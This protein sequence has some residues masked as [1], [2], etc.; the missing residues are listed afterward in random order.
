MASENPVSLDSRL[1]NIER[2]LAT[3]P[4]AAETEADRLLADVPGHGLAQLFKG[5]ARRLDGRFAAAIDI[6]E[7]LCEQ[8][9]D[10]PLAHL[11]LGLAHRQSGNNDKARSAIERAVATNANFGDGW[12]ALADL[13]VEIGDRQ[14]ADKA[15]LSYIAVAGHDPRLQ[16]GGAAIT[17][18]RL[19][20]AERLLRH[21][22]NQ[23]PSDVVALCLLADVAERRDNMPEAEELLTRCVELAP[24]YTRARHNLAVVLLRQNRATE[25]LEQ[26]AIALAAEPGNPEFRKLRAAILV[27]L[28]RYDESIEVCEK[29]LDEDPQQPTVLTSL[30]H[31]LKTVGRR[32]EAVDAYRRAIALAPNYGEPYWS[33]A[34]LKTNTVSDVEMK[35]IQQ[36]LEDENVGL[37]DRLHFHFALGRACE[38]RQDYER[39][40]T[41]YDQGNRIRLELYPYDPQ[42]L[43]DFVARSKTFFT[44]DFFEQLGQ[45]G[46]DIED[47]I[48]VLGLPRSGSTLIEQ[49]LASHSC[50]EGTSELPEIAAI[51]N[52]LDQSMVDGT[53]AGYPEVLA[54]LQG[55]ELAELGQSYIDQTRVHRRLKK[56]RFVDKMPNNF[57]HIGLI[58][59]ILPRAKI[60]D[61]RRHPLACGL[62]LFKE[63]FA[64]A[65]NFSYSLEYIGRYYR[66]Y[67]ELMA[68]FDAILP[69]RVHHVV[70]ERLVD[71]T[72]AEVRRMLDY[73]ELEF[74]DACLSFYKNKR[75][76]GTA[77][78]EQ[79]RKPIYTQA[80]QHWRHY[81]PWLE[82]L[83]TELGS[84]VDD[85]APCN[86][87]E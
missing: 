85:Y 61:I 21:I 23:H 70:Y 80:L 7:P 74:E 14:A 77:S 44:A 67:H 76:V 31:M 25:A 71:D 65:Q 39:S 16:Q 68:H 19:D 45:V 82:P 63:H 62:S 57:A 10:A 9:P 52:R 86:V 59:S 15:F 18:G 48:F 32:D 8:N 79:V 58:H 17:E 81:E 2:L 78:S 6:L 28:M 72:E 5:I 22:V 54:L 53:S 56:P 66:N 33:L 51:A 27:R 29:L 75:A 84:L 43:S 12:L 36:Q 11:Q 35:A 87:L 83:K 60:I 42:Q 41:H 46:S 40:F 47:P 49:I 20:D 64:H 69:G 34:N 37:R 38:D 26:S 73:C 3:D 24:S 1:A 13:L 50:V 30:G 4:A 55:A